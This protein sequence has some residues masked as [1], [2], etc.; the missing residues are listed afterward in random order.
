MKILKG[1]VPTQSGLYFRRYKG[2]LVW[3][4]LVRIIGES[5]FLKI[6]LLSNIPSTDGFTGNEY[7]FSER[8][9][10]TA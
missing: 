6:E 3:Q 10:I 4:E 8:I 1:T 5:P 7:E 2:S 9:D